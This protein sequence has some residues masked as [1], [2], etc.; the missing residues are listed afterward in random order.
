VRKYIIASDIQE[1]LKK[2][3]K[4]SPHDIWLEE[5]TQ[6]E[7]IFQMAKDGFKGFN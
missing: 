1:V 4:Q 5:G 2:E 3:K 7:I 6:K